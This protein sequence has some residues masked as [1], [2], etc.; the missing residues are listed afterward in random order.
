MTKCFRCECEKPDDGFYLCATCQQ[1][2]VGEQIAKINPRY[3]KITEH[4][5]KRKR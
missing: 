3:L 4:E 2:F 1:T 5:M